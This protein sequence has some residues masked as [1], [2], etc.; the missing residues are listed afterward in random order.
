MPEEYAPQRIQRPRLVAA[1]VGLLVLGPVCY[2]LGVNLPELVPLAWRNGPAAEQ[3]GWVLM[4]IGT[5][6]GFAG[7][8]GM[9]LLAIRVSQ[10]AREAWRAGEVGSSVSWW[11]G[12]FFLAG[13]A[14]WFAFFT[15]VLYPNNPVWRA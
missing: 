4:W 13:A 11:F 8:G 1:T 15:W 2:A 12:S 9:C 6:L 5:L 7:E 10:L 14:L 3:W